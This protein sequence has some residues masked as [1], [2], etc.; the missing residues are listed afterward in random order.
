MSLMTDPQEMRTYSA[1]FLGHADEIL[2]EATR[3][4]ASSPS[5]RNR[6]I[7]AAEVAAISV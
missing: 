1:K 3:A 5:A 7:V 2:S 4:F 6:L